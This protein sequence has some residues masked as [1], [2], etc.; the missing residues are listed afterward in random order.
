MTK[1]F[2]IAALLA[3]LTGP[4]AAYTL[5]Y[6][7]RGRYL[8]SK[9]KDRKSPAGKEGAAE[10]GT[11]G[12]EDADASANSRWGVKRDAYCYPKINDVMGFEFVGVIKVDDRIAGRVRET[13]DGAGENKPAWGESQGIG[14]SLVKTRATTEQDAPDEDDFDGYAEEN[15]RHAVPTPPADDLNPAVTD[16]EDDERDRDSYITP[17]VL[18]DLTEMSRFGGWTHSEEDF[19]ISDD[20]YAK[21]LA[22]GM[23]RGL[24]DSESAEDEQALE[25]GRQTSELA[26]IEQLFMDASDQTENDDFAERLMNDDEGEPSDGGH[27]DRQEDYDEGTDSLIEDIDIPEIS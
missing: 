11:E 27:E 2:I 5:W 6:L 8:K 16:D 4:P 24:V 18:K 3:I 7:L 15:E 20:D 21:I 23:D 25:D 9:Q 22:D 12:E 13:A 14:T 17:E 1:E 10:P 19:E 26:R